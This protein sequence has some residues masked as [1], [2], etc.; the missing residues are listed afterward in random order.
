MFAHIELGSQLILGDLTGILNPPF[1]AC[2]EEV[3]GVPCLALLKG[4]HVI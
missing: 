1:L 4:L 2:L 3:P